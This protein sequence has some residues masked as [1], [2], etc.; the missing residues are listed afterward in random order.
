MGHF[1]RFIPPE[2]IHVDSDAGLLL[3]STSFITPENNVVCVVMNQ[4]DFDIP[5]KLQ[6]GDNYAQT[7]IPAHA[8]KT[9]I[10]SL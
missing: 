10:W 4:N 2:S 6:Y 3:L 5:F 7:D 9:F 8:I 1:S